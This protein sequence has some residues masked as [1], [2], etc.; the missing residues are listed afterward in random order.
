MRKHVCRSLNNY[1]QEK[2][3]Q[4]LYMAPFSYAFEQ[5][6]TQI[7]NEHALL[8]QAV[9]RGNQ[10]PYMTEEWHKEIRYCNKSW[11]KFSRNCTNTNYDLYKIQ[12]NKCT[13]LR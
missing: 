1:T 7:L 5:L 10:V 12:H 2:F 4:D 13:A 3:L 6:Y 9:I 11:K 8:K